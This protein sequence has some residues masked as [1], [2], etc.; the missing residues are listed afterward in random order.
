MAI[1]YLLLQMDNI[2]SKFEEIV[3][4]IVSMLRP[5]CQC[6]FTNNGIRNGRYICYQDTPQYVTYRAEV[7]GIPF[8]SAS[9]LIESVEE[10]VASGVAISVQAQ[11]LTPDMTCKTSISSIDEEGCSITAGASS[12]TAS[13]MAMLVGMVLGTICCYK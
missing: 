9:Q 13:G 4:E 1:K 2:L 7:H 6:D 8:V 5:L 12:L 10:W 3:S 11:S